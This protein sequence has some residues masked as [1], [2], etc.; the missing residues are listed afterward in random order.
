M[1]SDDQSLPPTEG[2]TTANPTALGEDRFRTLFD[3]APDAIVIFDLETGRFV[4]ANARAC[5]LFGLTREELLQ[6]GPVDVSADIQ[7]DGTPSAV[8]APALLARAMQGE[9][10]EFEWLHRD[11]SGNPVLCEARLVRLPPF[12]RQL[13][14]GSMT[15]I[16]ERKRTEAELANREREARNLAAIVESA[17][18]AIMSAD[19]DGR[20][21]SW[22]N[23]AERMFGWTRDEV[24]GRTTEFLFDDAGEDE[25]S[26][27]R[28]KLLAGESISGFVRQWRTRDGNLVTTSSVMF[29]LLDAGGRMVGT[30]SV[31]RDISEERAAAEL[32]RSNEERMRQVL[33]TAQMGSWRYDI[34]N[35]VMEYSERAAAIYGRTLEQMPRTMAEAIDLFHPDDRETARSRVARPSTMPESQREYRIRMP[36][37]SYRWMG[38]VGQILDAGNRQVTGLI[39][40]VNER[41]LAEVALRESEEQLRQVVDSVSAGIWVF[42]G[43]R[44]VLVNAAAERLTGYSREELSDLNSLHALL[45]VEGTEQLLARAHARLAGEDVPERYELNI[46]TRSGESRQVD[47]V[48]RRIT[49]R[50]APAVIISVFDVTERHEGQAALQAS[51]ARFR[52]LVDNSPDFITR[53]DRDLR[54]DFVN[55][56]AEREAG[57]DP[58]EVLGKRADEMGF[59]PELASLF[60]AR[61]QQVR[62][63]GES[64]E[65]EYAIHSLASPHTLSYRRAR[66]VPEFDESGNVHHILSIVTDITAQRQAEEARKRLDQQMQQAQKLESLGVLAGGIAHDFNNLLVAILGN[67]GLALM[68]LNPES[69][70][71]QTVQDIELA[72]QRAAELTRQM[73]AYSGKGKFVIEPLNLSRVVEEMAHLLEV[74]VSK[75]ATLRFRFPDTLPTVEGDAT[76][77]R[78]VIMNLILNASDALGEKPGLISVSTGVMHADAEYLSGPYIEAGLPEGE[79]VYLEVADTGAGMDEGTRARIFDPFFSTK[80]A[81]RGLGLAAVLGI[82]RGHRGAIKLY[83]EVGKGS[84]FKV[85][86]PSREPPDNTNTQAAALPDITSSAGR[87]VLIVDD[88]PTV[89]LV[90]QRILEHAGFTTLLADDG[91]KGIDLYRANPGIALVLLD[92]T[93]PEMDGEEAFRELRRINGAVQVLL[94]SGYSE[95]EAT[96]SFA[97][98]G[99][100]GFLQKPYRPQDLLSAIYKVIAPTD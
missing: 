11:A 92:M 88:D 50:G 46:R 91:R 57:L 10:P 48:G 39:I 62:D 65:Y 16:R 80:F 3:H 42:D 70:A 47:I 6:R 31:A 82:V 60:L 13:V 1:T 58:G 4:E 76:Q 14:R 86:F 78:Q 18:D 23:G 90:T 52:S 55:K 67:A 19:M 97:G 5:T 72:A 9:T 43:E 26:E 17:S 32:I 75:W 59:D 36:D 21:I 95:Q 25:R 100:A 56:T 8:A 96:E 99:L 69:P 54:H 68:E 61:Q 35:D 22:N 81:G 20:I 71:R 87:T 49:F 74:S 64:I 63:S 44:I 84:T 98:K 73:L 30:A 37:G 34:Q 24:L 28:R 93:M 27:I 94:T 77:I 85:L 38:G 83:S 33:D 2:Q 45:G 40:D 15:D 79:Y 41:K 66:L 53:V 7:P 51:E 89:R 29:P 12:D